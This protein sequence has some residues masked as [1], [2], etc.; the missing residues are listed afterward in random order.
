MPTD[1]YFKK[2]VEASADAIVITDCGGVIQYVNHAFTEVTGWSAQ[3]SLGLTPGILKSG[4]TPSGVYE[5]MWATLDKGKT[6][7]G[8]VCN[9]HKRQP[10][11][12]LPVIGQPRKP[13]TENYYWAHLCISPVIE[14]G[15]TTAYIAVQ[16]DITDEVE[17]EQRQRQD[18]DD[19]TARANIAKVLQSQLP[20]KER[21]VES[22]G[23]L[24]ELPGMDIQN[25]G[26]VFLTSADEDILTLFVT[27]GKFSEEFF[28]KERTIPKGFCLCG[29][30]AVSGEMIVSD[31]C[32][33]DPR[34]E[35]T[36]EGMTAHGHY[37]VP[38][39]H[40]G[41]PVG[42]LFLYTDTYP[43]RNEARLQQL[44]SIGELMGLA[45]ANDRLMRQLEKEKDRA[46]SSN[47][48]KS[49]FLANM[50]HEIRTPL[51]GI[52]GFTDLLIQQGAAVCEPD[53]EEYLDSIQTSGKHLLTLIN[54]IL[55]LSKI[56]SESLDLELIDQ[57]PHAIL[58]EVVSLMRVPAQ[59]KG[60][61]L[62]YQWVGPLP[63]TI[64]TDPT[65]LQQ[66]IINLI[67]NAIKFTQ[68][69]SVRMVAQLES[70]QL[71]SVQLESGAPLESADDTANVFERGSCR[72]RIDVID[73]GIGIAADKL[74][75][76]F[77]AFSQADNSVTRRFGGTGL[78]L[79][80]SRRLAQALGGDLSVKSQLGV[81]STFTVT[82]DVGDCCEGSL[83]AAPPADGIAP[84]Q[85][86]IEAPAALLPSELRVLLVEDGEINQKLILALLTQAGVTQVNTAVN[87]QLGFEQTQKNP[88]D[89]I[90]LDMQMPVMDGY[91]AASAMRQ[92]GVTAPVIALTAHAMKGDRQKCI[93][94]G[95]TDYLT[96]PI[97]HA[98]LIEKMSQYC[99]RPSKRQAESASDPMTASQAKHSSAAPA[100]KTTL[101]TN[102]PVFLEIAQDFGQLLSDCIDGLREAAQVNDGDRIA[103]IAHD[104][105]GTAG[106]A[107]FGAFT[108]PAR[109]LETVAKEDDLH[110]I[111]TTIDQIRALAA[112]V[113]IPQGTPVTS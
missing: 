109:R 26:G 94:A 20:F 21:M 111:H 50:S 42:I 37:I 13:V 95:C 23:V 77:A 34:H 79:S 98:E 10:A 60:L 27:N 2:A 4:K 87:G 24:M 67:G 96:K 58:A 70:A 12:S 101:P 52:I 84:R 112:R 41:T 78:G 43:S 63:Q 69:G 18:R 55:D 106:G 76:V 16:R 56:E 31:D 68:Q 75:T 8:R 113:E 108:Q 33:C 35:Q 1:A 44:Q 9:K 82:I 36:F 51:N 93:D 100:I 19:A 71:E 90:L 32:F 80:I 47:R 54:D 5:D 28:E 40:A 48:A 29:R 85:D 97:V 7:T 30:A 73:S 102:N 81:G 66:T 105:V 57:S 6:W 64:R 91:T 92:A 99:P 59:E 11:P 89:I 74:E 38:L 25:K 107:G 46:E 110:E 103:H 72:L 86:S 53:R 14:E 39:I 83:Q 49:E 62:D 17:R 3:E 88:Y 65:R 45:I 61:R 104:L 22:L 15:K